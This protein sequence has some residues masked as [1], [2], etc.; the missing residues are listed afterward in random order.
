MARRAVPRCRQG[1]A[2]AAVAVVLL[3]VGACAGT[4]SSGAGVPAAAG[5][6]PGAAPTT[7]APSP[8]PN[9][10]PSP[11]TYTAADLRDLLLT[12]A[13]LPSVFSEDTGSPNGDGEISAPTSRCDALAGLINEDS[14]G[15][16]TAQ[17]DI[18]FDGGDSAPYLA[19]ELAAMP[20]PASAAAY[21]GRVRDAVASC[22][23]LRADGK[24]ESFSVSVSSA[25]PPA[26]G[27]QRFALELT[28]SSTDG[29]LTY[30]VQLVSVGSVVLTT[31]G[32]DATPEDMS[33]FTTDAYAKLT[34]GTVPPGGHVS[35]HSRSGG[36][37][38]GGSSGGSGR[39][40]GGS[41]G[42]GGGQPA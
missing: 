21:V 13:D 30:D 5:R 32:D 2:S 40:S 19:E 9:T 36:S 4:S 7:S 38:G 15:D 12:S 42:G 41:G 18:A 35:G 34:G 8:S 20:S 33:A 6:L 26:V 28:A 29:E 39:S 37:S 14:A 16:A 23:R 31:T 27:E 24:D 11:R 25:T 1:R 3:T 22:D 17:A 10:S